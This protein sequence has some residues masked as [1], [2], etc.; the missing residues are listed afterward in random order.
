LALFCDADPGA[1]GAV[2]LTVA[3]AGRVAAGA[4]AE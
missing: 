3:G 2:D 4:A 1:D